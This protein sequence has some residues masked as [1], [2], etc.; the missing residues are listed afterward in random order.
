MTQ[1]V[2]ALDT[3]AGIQRDG[4]V[5]DKTYYNDG[6]WV[7]FQRGR[8]RKVG[9]YRVISNQ[10]TGPSRGI[11]V[12]PQDAFNYIFSG[13]S[14]GLQEL[15]IDDNGVGAGLNNFTLSNFTASALNLWQFDGF[16]DVAGAGVNTLLAHPGQNLAAIDNTVN[17]PVLIG[18]INGTTMS[19][20]GVFTD[21]VTTTNGSPTI[22]LAATNSLIGAGQAITGAGIPSNTTVISVTSTT[23]TM[24]QNA[25]ASATVTATFN[26]N[27]SVSGGVVALHPYVFVYGNNGLIK[28][29]SA[30]N[31]QDWVS[32]DANETNVA[33]GKIVKGLP[34]R[35]GSNSP[36]G[37]FWSLDSLIRV[38]YAP[39]SLG[40]AGTGNFAPP[41]FWRYDIISSQT[42]IMS[43]QSVIE[44]DGVYYWCGVDRFLLYN[45]VVKEIPNT[46]NQNYFFDNLNYSQRQ[47]VWAT[48]VPRFG[49]IWWFYPRG[50]AT[51]CTDAIIYNVRENTW[52]DAGQAIG[53]R[54]S[55][56][57]FSQVFAY[58]VAAD[59]ETLPQETLLT[60]SMAYISGFDKI[61]LDTYYTEIQINDVVSGAD[62]PAGTTLTAIQSSGIKTLGSITGGSLYVDNTY[63]D[64]PL[65]GGAGA[66]ATA[67]ITVS[68]GA[69]TA[70][71]IVEYGAAY[72]VGDVLSASNTN[73][74]G[75]G[76]GF[77][78]PVASL[79][80]QV[81]TLSAAPTGSDTADLTFSTPENRIEVYQHEIGVD[82]INGQNVT[83]I[84]SYFET[85]DL[86]WVAGGPSQPAMDGA[87]R[88]LRL[89]RVEPD[90]LQNGEMS[91]VVTGRPY[92]QIQDQESSPYN[93]GPNTGKIDMKEQ[94]RELRLKFI[95]NTVGGD[96]QLGRVILNAD[97]GDVRG[98]S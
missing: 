2:F 42:S 41:T 5:F 84:E 6:R 65:T 93:F 46:L 85:S 39:Q 72:E 78:V 51:E 22:T 14:S 68:G 27:V 7:R 47:K 49:E 71:T 18:D 17:T 44:Y 13:Y 52:Y 8:P 4:T 83:A 62:I 34:V 53:A 11:W 32:A 76:S 56:G 36:S 12:N 82:A 38:S 61:A 19:Q 55:A 26:N 74:G 31:A 66:G 50:N 89:E 21:S 64:V 54:R 60:A 86:G 9:G 96:Y 58:P 29:C 57:Y 88:W 91:L 94:R 30:G 15:I 92:A 3:L 67:D 70:A 1:K 63:T 48:K 75:A 35:G 23:V 45:G 98:Y 33:T 10:M 20:I 37:L 59:W 95:S 97:I 40:I 43:S 90:F 81:L 69:V 79:Y 87:N 80:V 28:N 24:S 16:Y 73:L 25:T 77:S